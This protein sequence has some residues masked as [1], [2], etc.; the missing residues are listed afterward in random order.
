MLH[1]FTSVTLV[2]PCNVCNVGLA[3][4]SE[5]GGKNEML[6]DL[7]GNSA[8]VKV[9]DFLL[10]NRFWDYTKTDIATNSGISRTQLYRVWDGILEN[11]LV[12]FSRKIAATT[13]Y[14]TNLE[15]PI[16]KDLDRLS[17]TI[18]DEKNKRI[19]EAES[20]S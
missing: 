3:R 8:L 4:A 1:L 12:T 6:E 16:V 17:L 9:V 2:H 20:P 5:K 10:E 14:K 11:G 13:L 18:A 15:S 19:L 7:F